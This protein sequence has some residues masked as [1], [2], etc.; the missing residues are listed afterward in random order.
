MDG[1]V[2]K[3]FFR[4]LKKPDLKRMFALSSKIPNGIEPMRP[5]FET[6]VT[7]V[8]LAA[9][10]S[11]AATAINVFLHSIMHNVKGTQDLRR[12]N[13]SRLQQIPVCAH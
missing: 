9:V 13:S 11:V 7:T 1:A 6:H 2:I 5:L 12:N 10:Q 3:K 8:G 4:V